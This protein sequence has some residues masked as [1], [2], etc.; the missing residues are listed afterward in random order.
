MIKLFCD[1][2]GCEIAN[3]RPVVVEVNY[4]YMR[5]KATAP[6][7]KRYELCG[8][9]AARIVESITGWKGVRE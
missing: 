7:D 3:N 9:C 5:E 4:H 2:C 6:D 1:K 8:L